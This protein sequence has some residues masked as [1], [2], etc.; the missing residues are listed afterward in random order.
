MVSVFSVAVWVYVLLVTL[1]CG[2]GH[3]FHNDL[4]DAA[5]GIHM[6]PSSNERNASAITKVHVVFMNHLDIGYTGFV[7]E[8]LNEYL[9]DYFA[10]AEWLGKEINQWHNGS[11]YLYTTQPWLLS[12]F[13]DCPCPQSQP[14]CLAR[15]LGNRLSR[16][17]ECPSDAERKALLESIAAKEIVWNGVPFNYQA[18]NMSP[19]LFEASIKSVRVL[20]DLLKKPAVK[21]ARTTLTA[22][23]R[24]VIYV[25][26]GV[27]P[28]LKKQGVQ[29]LTVGSNVA[30]YPPQVQKL[31]VWKDSN[32]GEDLIAIYHPYGMDARPC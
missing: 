15:T 25:T 29:A 32:S 10:R 12:L 3:G 31:H 28:I 8:V 7:N 26:R 24:D 30:N 17:L 18:E 6:K 14:P 20:D 23:I 22:S 13:L 19:Q 16:P 27:I 9:H 2:C 11:N 1:G 4:S 5:N 21:A